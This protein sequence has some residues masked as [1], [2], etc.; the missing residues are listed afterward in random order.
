VSLDGPHE[1]RPYPRGENLRR[2]V[3]AQHVDR[4]AVER[5]RGA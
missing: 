4:G 3:C 2:L 5:E 1:R